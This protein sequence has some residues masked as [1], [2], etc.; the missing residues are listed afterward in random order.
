M[1]ANRLR[2]G[3][4]A[5]V[6]AAALVAGGFAALLAVLYFTQE[7]LIF[8]GTPLP[9]DHRFAFDT[10]VTEIAVPVDGATL[11]A[12]LFTQANPRGLVFFLHGNAGNLQSWTTGVD[13]WRR[14]N[15]DLFIFDY[16]GYGRSTGAIESEAQLHADVRAAFDAIAPRYAGKPIV[17]YGRSLGSGLAVKL[18]RDVAPDLTVLVTPFA[19]LAATA[20][21]AFPFVPAFLVKYP[22]RTDEL[23]GDV[24]SPL[25]L[26]HGTRDTVIPPADSA[27]LRAR[28]RA[29]VEFVVVDGAGHNDLHLFRG[30]QDALAERLARVAPAAP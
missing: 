6:T 2:A 25:L 1:H 23:I 15:F 17:V 12:L 7:R 26:I 30:Y 3:A 14:A 8:P 18:A 21:R 27:A 9:R 13:F 20:R 24:T 19:S 22:M 28:A 5:L 16:R 4:V 11:D 29:P 10:P